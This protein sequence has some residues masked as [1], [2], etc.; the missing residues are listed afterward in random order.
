MVREEHIK[1]CARNERNCLSCLKVGVWK[2]RGIRRG[3]NKGIFLLCFRSEDVIL[4]CSGRK[5]FFLSKMAGYE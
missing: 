3:I 5:L 1:S 2:L 4:T